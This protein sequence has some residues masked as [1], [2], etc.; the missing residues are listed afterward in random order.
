[1]AMVSKRGGC[2]SSPSECVCHHRLPSC[3]PVKHLF[4]FRSQADDFCASFIATG[5]LCV[6]ESVRFATLL[7]HDC[8]MRFCVV[9]I[10]ANGEAG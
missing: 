8:L 9:T 7:C 10:S 3:S 6:P 4:G 5:F 2:S 1:M